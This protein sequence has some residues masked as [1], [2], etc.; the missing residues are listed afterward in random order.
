MEQKHP[1]SRRMPAAGEEEKVSISFYR[2]VSDPGLAAELLAHMDKDPESRKQYAGLYLR[3][4]QSIRR[5][6]E[7]QARAKRYGKTMR[8][9]LRYMVLAPARIVAIVL[10][11]L[12]SAAQFGG[13]VVLQVLDGDASAPVHRA[14]AATTGNAEPAVK[15]APGAAGPDAKDGGTVAVPAEISRSA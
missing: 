15:V 11:P 8:V 6:R 1:K 5:E 10:R 4:K 2:N 9:V 13:A 7:R 12:L 14:S 3:C